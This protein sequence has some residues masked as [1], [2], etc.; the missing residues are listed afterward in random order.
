[1][2][3]FIYRYGHIISAFALFVTVSAANRA[4]VL[5]AHEPELPEAAQKLRKF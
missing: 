5:I 3:K 1:M 4:C 2:K